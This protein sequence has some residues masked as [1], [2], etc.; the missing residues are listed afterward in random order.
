MKIYARWRRDMASCND[1]YTYI[2]EIYLIL[3]LFTKYYMNK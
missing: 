1:D 2:L 3:Y